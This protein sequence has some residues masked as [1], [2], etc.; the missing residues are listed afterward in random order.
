MQVERKRASRCPLRFL[1]AFVLQGVAVLHALEKRAQ[2][3]SPALDFNRDIRPILAE[4]CFYCHGQD[5]NKRQA[6]LRLDIRD[7]AI[8]AGAIVPNDPRAS[9]LIS[10]INATSPQELMP[11]PKS[12]R[13]LTPEQ[14]KRLE[15]WI[16]EGANYATHWAFVTPERPAAPAVKRKNW[17]RNP[18]DRFVLAKLEAAGISPS[19]EADRATLI[20]RLSVD[21]TGLPPAPGNVDAF[22]ADTD[23]KAYENLVD[24]LLA[25]P[26]YGERMALP[27]LDAARYADSNGFQQDGDTW[28]W[29]WRDW[30][31]KALNADMPFDQFTIRLLA[32][33][34]LPGATTDD[35]IASG[36]NRNHLLN[37]EGGAI[38]EEQRF[39]NLFDRIH[40]PSPTSIRP[41]PQPGSA[42]RWLALSVTITNMIQ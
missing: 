26:H 32:G 16:E 10:R 13:R 21:L 28:Q 2:A 27:W 29:V 33:D 19:P 23:P 4:N 30:L 8:E 42:S 20:K 17:A 39:V 1:V 3:E 40:P 15:R 14:K 12:N 11:P 38:P 37:G 5:A 31:V 36:F 7:A 35:K 18:I 9:E 34:L 22:S 25:S 24:R 41:P 6:E